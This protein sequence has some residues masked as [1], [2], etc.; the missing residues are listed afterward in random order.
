MLRRSK[1]DL[2]YPKTNKVNKR[3]L[4]VQVVLDVTCVRCVDG[5]VKIFDAT[6]CFFPG[7]EN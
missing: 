4:G 5:A 3:V 2:V 1:P 7:L 6:R